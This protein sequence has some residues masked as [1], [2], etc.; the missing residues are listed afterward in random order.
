MNHRQDADATRPH[1]Q[2]AR[3][4]SYTPSQA[5]LGDDLPCGQKRACHGDQPSPRPTGLEVG[6]PQRVI[7]RLG[8]PATPGLPAFHIPSPGSGLSEPTLGL[9]PPILGFSCETNPI[10][11][12]AKEGQVLD[13]KGVM[14]DS[15]QNVLEKTNPIFAQDEAC[16]C[17]VEPAGVGAALAAGPAR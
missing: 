7:S 15:V 13:A 6:V 14:S 2:D 4:T 5:P 9:R 17:L 3:G 8:A 12:D 1:G 11:R 10:R 16:E